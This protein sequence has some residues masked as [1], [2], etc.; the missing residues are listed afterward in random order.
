M[1]AAFHVTGALVSRAARNNIHAI[2]PLSIVLAVVDLYDRVEVLA[3]VKA[4]EFLVGLA[5]HVRVEPFEATEEVRFE[6][7]LCSVDPANLIDLHG[8]INFGELVDPPIAAHMWAVPWDLDSSTLGFW[9]GHWAVKA[10]DRLQQ[11]P[12]NPCLGC[13]LL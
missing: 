6:C 1:L 9:A 8:Y 10:A 12:Q 11:F 7:E 3:P 5:F 4:L 13:L 2:Q